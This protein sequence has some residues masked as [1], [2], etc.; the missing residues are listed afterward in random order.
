[1]KHSKRHPEKSRSHNLSTASRSKLFSIA[2][3]SAARC[4]TRKAVVRV[5]KSFSPLGGK[6][7]EGVTGLYY[8]YHG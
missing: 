6:K 1:M 4:A 8:L 5:T 3:R 7:V 2:R